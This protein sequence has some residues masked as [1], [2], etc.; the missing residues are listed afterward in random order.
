MLQIRPGDL[1]AVLEGDAAILVA[2]VTKQILFGGHW[3]Y[4]FHGTQMTT[5]ASI[6]AGSSGFNAAVDFITPKR[7][8]RIVR[9]S[10]SNDFS[11]YMGPELL[12]QQPAKGEVN[13]QMW[14]WRDGRREDAERV[15]FTPSPAAE[16]RSAPVYSC[17]PA[18]LA[19]KLAARCWEP[20]ISM[21]DALRD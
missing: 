1:L 13:H 8:D 3:S 6:T 4:V 10:R 11:F 20:H 21:W 5:V 14:R 15:R 19:C 7:E 9:I 2:I 12:Q 18:D 17:I 16:E